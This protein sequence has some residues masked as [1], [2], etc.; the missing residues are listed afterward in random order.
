[1]IE[2]KK[3]KRKM[4]TVM[5]RWEGLTYPVDIMNGVLLEDGRVFVANEMPGVYNAEL[6]PEDG[7]VLV[8]LDKDQTDF[9]SGKQHEDSLLKLVLGGEDYCSETGEAEQDETRT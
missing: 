5:F 8:D 2:R 4:V 7:Y 3:V 1:M 6:L 9:I